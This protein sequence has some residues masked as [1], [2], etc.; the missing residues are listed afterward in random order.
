MAMVASSLVFHYLE[1]GFNK[2]LF[3]KGFARMIFFGV[4]LWV[5]CLT[6]TYH[7]YHKKELFIMGLNCF[8]LIKRHKKIYL[9][10]TNLYVHENIV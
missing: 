1:Q 5:H 2:K 4:Y 7:K 10:I 3:I 9:V 6:R 8:L